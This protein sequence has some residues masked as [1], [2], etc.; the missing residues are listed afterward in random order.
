MVNKS[1][2][3]LLGD[4]PARLFSE[5]RPLRF[6]LDPLIT[7]VTA[8]SRQV[9]RGSLFFAT[10]GG[11]TDGHDFI[12]EAIHRGA[13]AVAGTR[14]SENL[15]VPYIRLS[16]TREGL[17]EFAASLYGRPAHSLTVIGVTGTDG[18]TTTSSLIFRILLAAGLKAGMIS[19][20]NAVIG[21]EELD[22]GFHVT[23]PDAPQVQALLARM[24]DAGMTHVVLESTSH[25]LAQHRVSGC[26]F[27][28]AV[29]TNI[30]HEH[31]D[32]HG[33]YE[34]YRQAK[35]RLFDIS[36]DAPLKPGG[37]AKLGVLN[38]DDQS[39]PFLSRYVR[40][41]WV[42]Y[43]KSA[44]SVFRAENVR[45]TEDGL[46]FDLVDWNGLRMPMRSALRGEYN[47]ANILAA[48]TA[49]NRGLGIDLR[50]AA[51]GVADLAGIPGRME[52][53]KLGQDFMAIVDF[54]HTPNALLQALASARKMTTGKV[55]AV[56][57]SAGLRD[58]QKRRMMAETSVEEADI[59]VFTAEDPRTEPIL[60]ILEEMT[61][62][63]RSRGAVQDEQFYLEPDRRE[64]LRKAV[65]MARPGDLVI[66][67]GKGHEQS[68]C[69]GTI[70]YLWDDR[71]AL[72]AAVAER[73]GLEGYSMPF[74]P[75]PIDYPL[76][77]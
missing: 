19:T 32:Y 55:I 31:L 57:G 34:G 7:G 61:A 10:A 72:R 17:A 46:E 67:C 71:N 2:N 37:P 22:T 18:K 56:F 25:G 66:S 58:R 8:D 16:D 27:D 51:K 50:I 69:F 62:G 77:K 9:G 12:P 20:V 1:L 24:R 74:L 36:A 43:G 5:G 63:A 15:A 52:A 33:D 75:D 42:A 13:A 76:E 48:L 49:C 40:I 44:G 4:L 59:S 6:P 47:V 41:P 54:A 35:A 65:G 21:D 60:D 30:T 45:D 73:L 3:D 39:Y 70:E 11:Q 53:I 14:S 28:I 38:A 26:E 64:A 23:T 68:M 29:V